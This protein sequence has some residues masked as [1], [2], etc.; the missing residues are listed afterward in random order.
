[1]APR[2]FFIVGAPKCGTTALSAYLREHENIFVSWPKEPHYFCTDFDSYRRVV[3]ERDYL[4]L[5]RN[6]K[7]SH[8]AIGEASV[9]YMY[10][11][12]AIRNIHDF[13]REA[14]IIAML[15][16]PVEMLPSLHTQ[17]V[18]NGFEE[19]RDFEA[20]W[21]LQ[22]ER[23][24]GKAIPKLC[25]EPAF[26]QYGKIAS[27]S[28]QLRRVMR[29]FPPEQVKVILMD[30][31]ASSPARVY[32]ETLEFIG[33][34]DDGRARFERVNERK[35]QRWERFGKFMYHP[36]VWVRKVETVMKKA[37]NGLG[38]HEIKLWHR[39]MALNSKPAPKREL[40]VEFRAEL[41]GY[42]ASEIKD[43]STLLGQSMEQW[44]QSD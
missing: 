15:R 25:P 1:M 19:E 32:R 16:D 41:A 14:R 20:A 34:P 29:V 21:R 39:L 42:F 27:Y 3:S 40:S 44:S 38:V 2:R 24:S 8:L 36:P 7:D 5:F 12:E 28:T 23:R 10:S 37:L 13:D 30:D 22:R 43:L 17:L 33:V 9:W 26:L 18:Y 6:V 11:R 35:I 4:D 31:L